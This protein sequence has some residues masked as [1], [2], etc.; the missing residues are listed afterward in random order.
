MG[1]TTPP[2]CLLAEKANNWSQTQ[3]CYR[4]TIRVGNSKKK[5]VSNDGSRKLTGTD[6][7]RW[8]HADPFW[9]TLGFPDHGSPPSWACV[10]DRGE[11]RMSKTKC[12]VTYGVQRRS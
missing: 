9:K 10:L 12:G 1:G 8:C 4:P 3:P 2:R 6:E 7:S 11:I 5:K